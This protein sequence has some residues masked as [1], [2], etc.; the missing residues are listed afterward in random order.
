MGINLNR[1][2]TVR[3][4]YV[5]KAWNTSVCECPRDWSRSPGRT[6][7]ERIQDTVGAIP[8]DVETI[9][10]ARG[11]AYMALSNG[12]IVVGRIKDVSLGGLAFEFVKDIYMA[13]TAVG[14]IDLFMSEKNFYL[15]GL[16]SRVVYEVAVPKD[17]KFATFSSVDMYK[18][19]VRFGEMEE[20]QIAGLGK[21]IRIHD[22]ERE[23]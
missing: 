14:H 3:N 23:G 19:G 11:G 18:C 17:P 8:E 12:Q 5:W 6:E 4:G 9:L 21:F 7:K 22:R 1:S 16:P 2:A 20:N 15:T 10:D 13:L